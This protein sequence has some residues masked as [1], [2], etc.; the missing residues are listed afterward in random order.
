MQFF[1]VL[2]LRSICVLEVDVDVKATASVVGYGRGE[3]AVS[4]GFCG[5]FQVD[6]RFGV[7]AVWDSV[8]VKCQGQHSRSND[9]VLDLTSI[10]VADSHS[11]PGEMDM[12]RD[13]DQPL[14]FIC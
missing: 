11:L 3:G 6:E 14:L 13:W 1:G 12:S 2:R 9:L 7:G 8:A 10:A 4:C 5:W